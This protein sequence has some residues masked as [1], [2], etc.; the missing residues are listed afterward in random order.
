MIALFVL[1]IGGGF[2]ATAKA[3]DGQKRAVEYNRD[4]RPILSEKCF[5]CHGPDSASRQAD[6]RLDNKD[7]AYAERDGSRAIVPGKLSESQVYL[8]I[9]S[10]DDD[11]RMP[12]VDSGKIL[13]KQ[14]IV[15]LRR[16]IAQGAEYQPHW[17]FITPQ[18]PQ[19]PT[20]SAALWAKNPI[21]AF[22]LS[23]LDSE[24]LKPS[25]AASKAKLL[26][27]V[28][29]DLTG[30]PPTLEQLDAF[31]TDDS[32]AAYERAVDRLLSSPRYGE[33]MAQDWLDAARFADTNGFFTDNQR[34][35][36]RWRD[37]V[38]DAY[39]QNMPFDRFT[40]EQLAGDLLA[41][42]TLN[43]K[44]AT[45]FNRNHMVN[46]ETGIIEEEYRVE[47]VGDRIQTTAT[48]WLGLTVGCA[49]CHDHKFDPVSQQEFYQLFAFFNNVPERG[50]AGSAG[51]AQPMLEVL[52]AEE[53]EKMDAVRR[54]AAAA[55]QKLQTIEPDLAAAQAEWEKTVSRSLP[56]TLQKGL[57][58]HY[59]FEQQG[60]D[61]S[62]HG[63]RAKSRGKLTFDTGLLG[64]AAKFDGDSLLECDGPVNFDHTDPFTY[65][66]WMFLTSGAPACVLS[67][68]DDAQ[69][70][71]GF[72]LMIRKGKAV[73]HLVHK[74]NSDAIQVVARESVA[75][76]QWQHVMVTYD[77]SGSAR[78]VRIYLDGK[79]VEL[80]VK[81][82]SL[83]G[84]IKTKQPLRIGRRSTSA[85]FVGLIDDVR[86][87]D[88][89]LTSGEVHRLASRQLLQ[90][91]LSVAPGQR[92]A[93]LRSK[94]REY[95]VAHH[96][97][98]R[99][100]AIVKAAKESARQQR[101]ITARIPTTMVMQEMDRPRKTYFLI[102][103]QYDQRGDQVTAGVPVSLP[104]LP[105][106]A[107]RNRLG[108]ARWLVDPSH[109]LT[110]RVAVNRLWRRFFGIGIVKTVEDFGFQGDWPSHPKLLDY[111]ATEFIRSGWDVKHMQ[112][113]IATSATYRQSPHVS[114][115]LLRMDPANRLLA[116]GPRFRMNA[117]MLRDNALAISG[118]LV[119]K[120]GGPSVNP[121]QPQGLWKEV[122]Y[123]G[124]LEYQQDHGAALY[125]RGLYTYWKRQSPPPA[126]LAFDAPTRETC[127]PRRSRTNTP[128]QALV[129]M[130]DPT[131]VEAARVLA[132]RMMTDVDNS[133]ASGRV[134]FAFRL[135]TARPPEPQETRILINVYRDQL[136]EFRNKKRD[137]L[138]LVEVGEFPRDLSLDT[139]E[140]A[141]WTTV[142]GMIHSLDET[143]TKD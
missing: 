60:A 5:R 3:D 107:P 75:R 95:Y 141:A 85:P 128:M 13:S 136:A 47:Y 57:V 110:A 71:R 127:T 142:A 22:V 88:R 43:Q 17:S 36:W 89:Q 51:N 34:A 45:G 137:A 56:R 133:D 1:A 32:P 120:L 97:E 7:A 66:T 78:G 20:T 94:L 121:Y 116:R 42:A 125:R 122:S 68:N 92:T 77:G 105:P 134:Q 104:P 62:G 143:V 74:W 2:A 65:G 35:M 113:L 63:H 100:R 86:I 87:Y 67:K 118:L 11:E 6:L 130:N 93:S 111:L 27:R 19:L 129:L 30:L 33:H 40:I 115:E 135:A 102:R 72:D 14:E 99:W 90:G 106:G 114:P 10:S 126:M 109:P 39:N 21:D 46:N 61:S 54:V 84:T 69:S 18:R 82:D 64:T 4:V 24:G 101:E 12:P 91:I 52:T 73:A 80:V 31:L 138:R 81:Y 48:V 37:W 55:R 15:T 103:G 44:I 41:G 49:R 16:W 9:T 29:L 96:A 25:P 79:S 26:R 119:D 59:E 76:N 108:L 112:R 70:L 139:A 123:D 58:A 8:R 132:Q 83:T 23:R 124:G 38:I 53:R 131:Y 50:L 28:T 117:E 98:E 140:L